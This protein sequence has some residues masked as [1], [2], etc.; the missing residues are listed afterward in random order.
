M[1][2]NEIIEK[3]ALIVG[4][5]DVGKFIN[6]DKSEMFE[7][8]EYT[9]KTFLSLLNLVISELLQQMVI[10]LSVLDRVT[11]VRTLDLPMI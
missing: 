4:R 11:I 6:D 2:I 8:T 5:D 1:N 10:A 9:L 3:A 7:D